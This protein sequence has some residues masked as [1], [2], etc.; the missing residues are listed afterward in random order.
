MM[1]YVA[2]DVTVEMTKKEMKNGNFAEYRK[3]FLGTMN[4]IG[5]GDKAHA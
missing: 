5:K 3:K 1:N 4:N 2:G